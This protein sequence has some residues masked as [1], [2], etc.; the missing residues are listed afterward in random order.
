MTMAWKSET[1]KK[2]GDAR[3]SGATDPSSKAVAK[4]KDAMTGVIAD[5]RKLA[6]EQRRTLST[7]K[8]PD[9]KRSA[10]R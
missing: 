6:N 8:D 4:H 1:L 2:S 3:R 7:I 9:L 10:S 5:A